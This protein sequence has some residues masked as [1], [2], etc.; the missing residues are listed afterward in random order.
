MRLPR[1]GKFLGRGG[2]GM[3]TRF[4]GCRRIPLSVAETQTV[5]VGDPP[6]ASAI[7]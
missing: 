6:V 1:H 2:P 7:G 3:R 5:G 4:G